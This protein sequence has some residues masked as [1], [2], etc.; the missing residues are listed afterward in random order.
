M[1]RIYFFSTCFK[2]FED[3]NNKYFCPRSITKSFR[4]AHHWSLVDAVQTH[5]SHVELHLGGLAWIQ[6]SIVQYSTV[7]WAGLNTGQF[8]MCVNVVSAPIHAEISRLDNE[9]RSGDYTDYINFSCTALLLRQGEKL[10][11]IDISFFVW[12]RPAPCSLLGLASPDNQTS[13]AAAQTTTSYNIS[14]NYCFSSV[15]RLPSL[16]VL[17]DIECQLLGHHFDHFIFV[18]DNSR[19]YRYIGGP[20]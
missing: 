12:R 11:E 18:E 3:Q 13:P 10:E 16:P 7:Q 8:V 2:Y 5:H 4:V 19:C 9:W 14:K 6:Y 15:A 1:I 17:V 20:P